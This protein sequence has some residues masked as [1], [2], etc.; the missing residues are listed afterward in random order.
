[1]VL[2]QGGQITT[3]SGGNAGLGTIPTRQTVFFNPLSHKLRAS[4]IPS[5]SITLFCI[6]FGLAG[7]NGNL[8]PGG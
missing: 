7:H 4:N 8:S 5:T 3:R 6:I 2:T 1:M